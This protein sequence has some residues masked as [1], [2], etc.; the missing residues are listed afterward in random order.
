MTMA[1]KP[2]NEQ[3]YFEFHEQHGHTTAESRELKKALHELA[4][5]G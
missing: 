1:S 2:H 5:K 3:K 4:D